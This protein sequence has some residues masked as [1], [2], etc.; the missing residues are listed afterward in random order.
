MYFIRNKITKLFFKKNSFED[1]CLIAVYDLHSASVSF[2]FAYFLAGADAFSTKHKKK[3]FIVHIIKKDFNALDDSEYYSIVDKE[4]LRWR[5]E[6]IVIPL[7]GLYPKC[8]GYSVFPDGKNAYRFIKGR[9]TFPNYYSSFYTPYMDYKEVRGLLKKYPFHG[10]EAS[11]QGIRYIRSW[12]KENNIKSPIVTITIR[13]YGFDALRNSNIDEWIKFATWVSKKG[14]T[15]VFIPDTDSCFKKDERLKYFHIF[16]DPCWNLGLRMAIYE[17]SYLNFVK[18]GPALIAQLNKNARFINMQFPIENTQQS[19]EKSFSKS[20][21]IIGNRR[22]DFFN[23]FQII[24]WEMDTFD[25]ISK[26][27]NDFVELEEN[28]L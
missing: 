13:Q 8:S 22:F 11:K 21:Q 4:S 19:T 25:K 26:E 14:Y 1:D 3:S 18:D 17:E 27:F 7:I 9:A 5:F 20:G 6:N 16:R 28:S 10:F 12:I 2:D 24:S 15:P 23:K